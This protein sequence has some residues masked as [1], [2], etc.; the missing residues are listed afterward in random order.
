MRQGV[1]ITIP[2]QFWYIIVQH[3]AGCAVAFVLMMVFSWCFGVTPLKE[4]ASVIFILIYGIILYTAANELAL[5]DN[6]PYTP[7][8]PRIFK[9]FL[10]GLAICIISFISYAFYHYSWSI[11]DVQ[12]NVNF[13][14]TVCA[15]IIFSFWTYPYV[16]II[17][18]S[19]GYV[20]MYSFIL[21]VIVPIAS[22]M[23]GY[24]AGCRGFMLQ[25]YIRK[26]VYKKDK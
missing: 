1:K 10:W 3:L 4:I 2:Y 6:K 11:Y 19:K 9:S 24:I 12:N 26:L 22:C 16:G 25:E 8:K 13:T 14:L 15:N 17:G 18:A 21:W 7:L 5:Q 23:A 20:M